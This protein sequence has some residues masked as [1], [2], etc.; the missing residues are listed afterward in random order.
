M[1]KFDKKIKEEYKIYFFKLSL[2]DRMTD[3]N[4][5][6]EFETNDPHEIIRTLR[7]IA[8]EFEMLKQ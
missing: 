2:T 4:L 6:E 8:D 3:E 7:N 5:Y 1:T